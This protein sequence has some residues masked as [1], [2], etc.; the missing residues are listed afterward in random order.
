[1]GGL[2]SLAK[3]GQTMR[4]GE[5]SASCPYIAYEA[6]ELTDSRQDLRS[7]VYGFRRRQEP[8]ARET[9]PCRPGRGSSAHMHEKANSGEA[10]DVWDGAGLNN[11]R[12]ANE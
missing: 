6:A 5:S 10:L 3:Q 12:P 8:P 7:R 1:M 11:R 4:L 9:P 2:P